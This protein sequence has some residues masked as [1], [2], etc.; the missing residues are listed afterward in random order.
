MQKEE[1]PLLQLWQVRP[2]C[3]TMFF[4]DTTESFGKRISGT[5]GANGLRVDSKALLIRMRIDGRCATGLLDT[6]CSTTVVASKNPQFKEAVTVVG[7]GTINCGR[8][9]CELEIE[10]K[11]IRIECLTAVTL[12]DGVDAL[13]GMDVIDMLGGLEIRSLSEGLETERFMRFGIE[14]D[15]VCA[16]GTISKGKDILIKDTDFEARFCIETKKWEVTW[17]LTGTLN[18]AL[19]K[20][21]D[22]YKI[23]TKDEYKY[24]V[25]SWISEG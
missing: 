20:D 19:A 4:P 25:N 15:Q 2:Y 8:K 17:H 7:G 12:V 21:V 16:A 14:S 9:K 10:D 6:G 13:I 1:Q 5:A 18:D 22:N 11:L 24:E 3:A 23:D